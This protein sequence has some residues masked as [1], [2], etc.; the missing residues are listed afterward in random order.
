MGLIL[1]IALGLMGCAFMLS[2]W[3]T[4]AGCEKQKKIP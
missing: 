3:P 4:D 1:F 2:S